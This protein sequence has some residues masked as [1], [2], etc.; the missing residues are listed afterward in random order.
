MNYEL[1]YEIESR[2]DKV[3]RLSGGEYQARCPYHDDREPSMSVNPDKNVFYCHACHEKG[4]LYK[5]AKDLG[6]EFSVG[7]KLENSEAIKKLQE[8]RLLKIDTLKKFEVKPDYDNQA[9]KYPV[10]G[11]YRY[12]NYY[13]KEEFKKL[14]PNKKY[15]KYWHTKGVKNQ[16]Y[17]LIQALEHLDETNVIYYVNG[18]PSV[19]T[20]WQARIPA[21]SSIFGEGKIPSDIIQEFNELGLDPRDYTIAVVFDKDQT[22]E[23]ASIEAYNT[24]KRLGFNVVVKQLPSFLPEKSD[25]Q[26]LYIYLKGDDSKFRATLKT[27]PEID[28]S[29]VKKQE[30]TVLDIID[31]LQIDKLEQ[32]RIDGEIFYRLYFKNGEW[33]ELEDKDLASKRRFSIKLMNQ[34]GVLID[35][36]KE[37]KELINTLLS[38]QEVK[39]IGSS[40]VEDI[41]DE[42][43][44]I[45]NQVSETDDIVEASQYAMKYIDKEKG[46]VYIKRTVIENALSKNYKRKDITEAIDRLGGKQEFVHAEINGK[47]KTIRMVSFPLDILFEIEEAEETQEPQTNPETNTEINNSEDNPLPDLNQDLAQLENDIFGS[48]IDDELDENKDYGGD[49]GIPI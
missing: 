48:D 13:T 29:K 7:K 15:T 34:I 43:Q 30:N 16:V 22:G 41:Q 12:K 32:L 1:W 25:V 20:C 19:W 40:I 26:D 42:I 28:V 23:K 18:E 9:Y 14:F 24:L 49:D 27:L 11:G 2:L 4:T 36:G 33:I 3:K 6:I 10:K 38:N 37:F 31:S 17:G 44:T 21:I 46:K 35:F 8:Q 39:I 5:L 47:R 45:L